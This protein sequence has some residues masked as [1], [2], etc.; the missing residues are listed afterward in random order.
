[1]IL[2]LETNGSLLYLFSSVAETKSDLEAVDIE[3]N[4]YEFCDDT[5][6]RFVGK[7]IT[8]VS[9][10]GAGSFHL[11]PDGIPDRKVV[12]SFLSRARSLD[13]S[14]DASRVLKIYGG[15]MMPNGTLEL[16]KAFASLALFRG[17]Q[18][19]IFPVWVLTCLLS[20]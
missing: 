20:G 3:N 19:L 9:M 11:K 15:Y 14:C 10:F 16:Q 7:V 2:A 13:R 6:Q 12:A 1:M 8:P 17:Y 5:G 18:S 4:E